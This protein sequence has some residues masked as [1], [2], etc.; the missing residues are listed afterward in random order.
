MTKG[1]VVQV[2][3]LVLRGML[4][5][6][7]ILLGADAARATTLDE[8]GAGFSNDFARPTPVL[9]GVVTVTG[10]G[11][12]NQHDFLVFEGLLP[13]EQTLTISFTRSPDA[14]PGENSEG[15]V[16]FQE[17][18]F[19]SA[20]DGEDAGSFRLTNGR[21]TRT[22]EIELED[23]FAG[24]KLHVGLYFTDGGRVS[25]QISAPRNVVPPTPP[26]PPPTGASVL[27]PAD[28]PGGAFSTRWNNPTPVAP[29]YEAVEGELG[30][31]DLFF[32][33]T[34]LPP[35]VQT[36][37]FEFSYP[38]GVFPFFWAG[39]TVMARE[40]PFR[41][42]WDG[43]EIGDFAVNPLRPRS[44]MTLTTG[45]NFKG[46]LHVGLYFT[47][48]SRLKFRINAPSNAGPLGLP[49]V[50]AAKSV[51]V[52]DQRGQGC[53][54]FGQTGAAPAQAA[55]PGACMEFVID[56]RNAG[57]GSA[58]DIEIDDLL[59]ANLV[60]VAAE[61]TGFDGP[62]STADLRRPAGN[63]DCA[64]GTCRISLR[65]G[66]LSPGSGGRIVIRTLLK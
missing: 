26:P 2:L 11:S 37:T 63:T 18:P 30:R 13:G 24:G 19:R 7:L 64:T 50:Q 4:A 55:I 53:A 5:A 62:G 27:V 29:G 3:G 16:Y 39:G 9:G 6:V 31:N 38:D 46:V 65:N 23:D 22:V 49:D 41:W 43:T 12:T 47:Y 8:S 25:Y 44:T 21:R 1:N 10:T 45:P 36:L 35:G 15:E 57:D 32:V 51:R 56:A 14:R 17:R 34:D 20:W 33:F 59:S 52:I 54:A 66:Y 48:G 58:R 61:V 60:F 42:N 28:A 40:G